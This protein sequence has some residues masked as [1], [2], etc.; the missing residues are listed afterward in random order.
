[1]AYV[2]RNQSGPKVTEVQARRQQEMRTISFVKETYKMFAASLF[3]GALGAMIGVPFAASI[4]EMRLPL[5]L[6]ELGLL[7]GLTQMR[8][9]VFLL[10]GFTFMTGITT[11]P[12]IAYTLYLPGGSG[13]VANAFL[14]TSFIFGAMSFYAIKTTHDFTNYTKPLMIALI[15]II[16]FSFFNIAIFRSPFYVLLIS[17]A[18][19]LLFT[20][21]VVYD[22]QKIIKGEYDTPVQAAVDLYLDFLNIFVALLRIFGMMGGDDDD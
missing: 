15:G 8:D 3:A 4:W 10:Y 22:T 6:L 13:I 20:V 19:V 12:L 17:G 2:P 14:M 1:M 16:I 18:V 21:F 9:N 11:A 7:F 5:I